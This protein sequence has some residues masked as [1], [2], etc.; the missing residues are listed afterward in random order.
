MKLDLNDLVVFTEVARRGSFTAAGRE[1]DLPASAV[2]RRVARLEERLGMRLL[3]RTTRSVGL[4]DAGRIYYGRTATIR[5]EVDDALRAVRE[6]QETP[7]GRLRVTA[8]PDD[9]GVIWAMFA[10]FL[11]DHP[12]V[13]LELIHT[14]ERLDLIKEGIDVAL[15]G[16]SPPDSTQL[17]ATKL[18]DSRFVLVASPRY[19]E[20]RGVPTHPA[21]LAEHACIAMD[22]WVPNA[23]SALLGPE[24]PVRV[25][26]RNRLRTNS[27]ETARKAAIDGLG[28][29]PMVAFTC[30]RELRSGALVEVL[31]GALPGPAPMW[32]I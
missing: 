25:D 16:G 32:A 28:I 11:R 17:C 23:F 3:N 26:L 14:L 31:P 27:Q 13:E 8:P 1:L 15:R 6:F 21:E 29:A 30:W 2:S 24:G 20:A 18:V 12:D 9:G 22:N 10:E 5:Q 4:T 7:A 19:L